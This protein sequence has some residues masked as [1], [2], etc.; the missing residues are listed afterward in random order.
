[1]LTCSIVRFFSALLLGRCE[2]VVGGLCPWSSSCRFICVRLI[3]VVVCA[4]GVLDFVIGVGSELQCRVD[5]VTAVI[6]SGEGE[7]LQVHGMVTV[8]DVFHGMY[9]Q[10]LE[11][12]SASRFKVPSY[13][14]MVQV[15]QQEQA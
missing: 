5:A 6:G 14:T 3:P 15:H 8:C 9:I 1:M 11:I 4:M 10:W 13:A 2:N 12:N 7:C